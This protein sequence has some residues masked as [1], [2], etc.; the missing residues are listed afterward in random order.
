MESEKTL[1]WLSGRFGIPKEDIVWYNSGSCYSRIV[2]KTE[3]SAKKVHDVVC[4]ETV[5]G[6]MLGGMPLG[7]ISKSPNKDGSIYYDVTC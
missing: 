7:G 3:A 1:Q 6:G 4:H 5:N 2:V